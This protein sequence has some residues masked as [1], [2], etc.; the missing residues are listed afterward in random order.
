MCCVVGVAGICYRMIFRQ[1]ERSMSTSTSGANQA[2]GKKSTEFCAK[3]CAKK[4]GESQRQVPEVWKPVGQNGGKG[5]ECGFDGGKRIKGRKRHIFVDTN[6]LLLKVK[7]T[8]A[9]IGDREGAKQT[10]LP[11]KKHL[12][13]MKKVWLDGGYDGEPF[14]EWALNELGWEVEITHRPEGCKGFQL[15]PRRWVV[16]RTF[17][18]IGKFRRLS[19]DYEYLTETS[20]AFIYA[21]MIHVMVRRLG[22]KTA[23]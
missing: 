3:Q 23:T 4:K 21:A 11:L 6:G 20:E 19:K 16:E 10:M 22:R 15:V 17:A 7:V 2:N 5:G 18:W 12:S 13:R 9:N 8:A 1:V 14:T